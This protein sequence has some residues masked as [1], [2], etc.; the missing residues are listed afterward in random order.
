MDYTGTAEY[1]PK[2]SNTPE[3]RMEGSTSS[4]RIWHG[5]LAVIPISSPSSLGI[6]LYSYSVLKGLC[7]GGLD[8]TGL[9]GIC[10]ILVNLYEFPYF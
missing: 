6:G 7:P 10:G 2:V 8:F 1:S 5:A 3:K 4:D 9:R